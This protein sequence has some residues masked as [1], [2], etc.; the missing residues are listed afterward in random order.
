MAKT[1]ISIDVGGILGSIP[2]EVLLDQLQNVGERS[3][4]FTPERAARHLEET[5]EEDPGK[6][7][8]FYRA[9]A[10]GKFKHHLRVNRNVPGVILDALWPL[11]M[12]WAEGVVDMLLDNGVREQI[13]DRLAARKERDQR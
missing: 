6:S 9:D 12:P 5:Q 10:V 4:G 2:Q 7:V 8:E 11:V 13:E 3:L 1:G